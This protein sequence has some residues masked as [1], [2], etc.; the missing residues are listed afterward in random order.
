MSIPNLTYKNNLLISAPKID[1]DLL[2]DLSL[3]FVSLAVIY[4]ISVF[5]YR[6]RISASS[7]NVR[8]RKRELSPMISEFLFLEEDATKDEKS[9]Y[10][11][12]KIEIRQL[13]KDDFN[14]KVLSEILLD[15][16]K[17]I[18]GEAQRTLFK[19]YQDLE[20]HKDA[21]AKLSSW[22]WEVIS[23][24]IL[25]LTQM[26]VVEAYGFITKFINDKRS[27]IRKQAEIATVTLRHEGINYFLDTTKYKISEWQQLKLLDVIRNKEDFQPP[28]FKA[29]LTS[30]NKYVV[31]FALRLIKYYN[32]NDANTSLIELVKHKNNQIKE[33]AIA[34]IKEFNVTASLD[35]LKLVFWNCTVDV[36][37]TILD[38]IA[39]IGSETD[40]EF[41]NLI[42]KKE[43]NFSV[44]SKAL[45]SINSISPESI[46]PS[47]GIQKA[48]KYK[49]PNDITEAVAKVHAEKHAEI[50]GEKEVGLTDEELLQLTV[51]ENKTKSPSDVTFDETFE[52]E[53]ENHGASLTKNEIGTMKETQ[54]SSEKVSEAL[55]REIQVIAEEVV[56]KNEPTQ[57]DLELDSWGVNHLNFLPIVIQDEIDPHQKKE[58]THHHLFEINVVFEEVVPSDAGH[59]TKD[60]QNPHK[61]SFLEKFDI[62]E[63]AFL[64]IVVDNVSE[65]ETPPSLKVEDKKVDLFELQVEFDEVIPEIRHDGETD[66]LNAAIEFDTNFG[67]EDEHTM[68]LKET[69]EG[70]P[71]TYDQYQT[72]DIYNAPV[73]YEEISGNEERTEPYQLEVIDPLIL[74]TES[75]SKNNIAMTYREEP[76]NDDE[77]ELPMENDQILQKI[78]NDLI[79][80]DRKPKEEKVQ[81]DDSFIN[82]DWDLDEDQLEFI[83]VSFE[84]DEERPKE[85]IKI[86]K[87]KSTANEDKIDIPQA[88]IPKAIFG[89]IEFEATTRKLLNDL[90]E[91]GD[92]R[93]IPFLKELLADA[94]YN[95]FKV[96]INKL[97]DT[98]NHD[99][100]E[101]KIDNELQPFSVF[102]DLFRTCDTEAKLI[103]LDEVVEVGDEKE[104]HFL[105]QLTKDGS[106][107]VRSKALTVLNELRAK[108]GTAN[109]SFAISN[110]DKSR[111]YRSLKFSKPIVT[112][113]R[114]LSSDP[115]DIFDLNFDIASDTEERGDEKKNDNNNGAEEESV[116]HGSFIGQICS[117]S[118]K[119][120][121]K[122]NG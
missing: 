30:N 97:I 116:Q 51:I 92:Q 37:I 32:Q 88:S 109:E 52:M 120:L 34:C 89:D 45:S 81:I 8:D 63:L 21:F 110:D 103:L 33:E 16:R 57:L 56:V 22:R 70:V 59:P 105:E 24:G 87:N 96:R 79:S 112:Y 12:L 101:Q 23:K 106:A 82:P 17:D 60:G 27:T 71:N 93:E 122:L 50:T 13:L 49:I 48:S 20:L 58:K 72:E 75:E 11:A 98:F 85:F 115:E 69:T 26:E 38:A 77:I 73:N 31:L 53:G 121:E 61:V 44:K 4:F 39:Q 68:N 5:F 55:I 35:T 15:L 47:K 117:F 74:S 90:E 118:H 36:K 14:R 54:N 40:V 62:S 10:I 41:L 83:P 67:Q 95:M 99:K 19:L 113:D 78:I 65:T 1:T 80:F 84:K 25:E 3:L 107:K 86:E 108:L 7:K 91:M 2:W 114:Q 42:E 43:L 29:W 18:A 104:L 64:P 6:N 94:K 46:M 28:R 100:E 66:N 9:N 111:H 102:Q 76:E 119:I